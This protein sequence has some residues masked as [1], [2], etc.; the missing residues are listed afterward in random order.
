[1]KHDVVIVN[2]LNKVYKDSTNCIYIELNKRDA[3]YLFM[4]EE[5]ALLTNDLQLHKPEKSSLKEKRVAAA[6]FLNRL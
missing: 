2:V 6:C 4:Y 5:V 3:K 1:M